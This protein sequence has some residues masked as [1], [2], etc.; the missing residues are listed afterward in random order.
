M[1]L[2]DL[3]VHFKIEEAII[4][5]LETSGASVNLHFLVV[6]RDKKYVLRSIRNSISIH[7]LA[8]INKIIS[9]WATDEIP[10]LMPILT[11]EGS[12]TLHLEDGTW[13]LTQYLSG[14]SYSFRLDEMQ[15]S[16]KLLRKLHRASPIA[17]ASDDWFSNELSE[18][19]K[20]LPELKKW[21]SPLARFIKEQLYWLNQFRNNPLPP[22]IATHGDFHGLNLLFEYNE[23][24]A[25][26]DFDNVNFRPRLYDIAHAILMFCRNEKGSYKIRPLWAQKFLEAYEGPLT[27][28]EYKML[29]AMMF[30]SKI[31]SVR[32]L[33]DLSSFGL[34]AVDRAD[35]YYRV[36]AAITEQADGIL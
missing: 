30:I 25:L 24:K 22:L 15:K 3:Q 16:S 26:L 20:D 1:K 36:L 2:P 14:S 10:L 34:N 18:V 27:Q 8:E 9:K 33:K 32:L 13:Q 4:N 12:H 35:Y 31:P 5:P 29:P 23:V 28:D 21:S 19:E 7:R 17:L 11:E 6:H